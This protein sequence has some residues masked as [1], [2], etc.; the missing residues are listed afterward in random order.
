MP[1]IAGNDKYQF[2]VWGDAVNV[3]A[4]ME[5]FAPNNG[6]CVS[7]DAFKAISSQYNFDGPTMQNVKGRGDYAIYFYNNTN[8]S[9]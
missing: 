5:S 4:R 6:I 3:A 9:I 2:D 1:G 8:K 7:E